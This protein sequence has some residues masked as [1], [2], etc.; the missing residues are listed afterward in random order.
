MFLTLCFLA[1]IFYNE[2]GVSHLISFVENSSV[3]RA[4]GKRKRHDAKRAK[5]D[6]AEMEEE[7]AHVLLDWT[8]QS[9]RRCARLGD[10]GFG[11]HFKK[12]V[13]CT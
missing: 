1:A 12:P 3:R 7:G 11:G 2:M 4:R 6:S 5:T 8:E 13:S 9:I 10:C